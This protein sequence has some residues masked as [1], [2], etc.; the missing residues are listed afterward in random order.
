[1]LPLSFLIGSEVPRPGRASYQGMVTSVHVPQ[2]FQGL[3]ERF[4]DSP[5]PSPVSR[6]SVSLVYFP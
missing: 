1:M 6:V 2:Q 4:Q 3:S 5:L